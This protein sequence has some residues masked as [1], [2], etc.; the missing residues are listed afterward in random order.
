MP[1]GFLGGGAPSLRSLQLESTGAL[2]KTIPFSANLTRVYLFEDEEFPTGA[3][4]PTLE[5]FAAFLKNSVAIEELTLMEYLP[6]TG[7]ESYYR[8]G[9]FKRAQLTLPF[10]RK[11]VIHDEKREIY[12]FALSVHLPKATSIHFMFH[13]GAY[14]SETDDILDD[15]RTAWTDEERGRNFTEGGAKHL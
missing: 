5:E 1:V 7:F 3:P 15:L 12:R 4:K 10:L 6:R 11:L 2:W 14:P 8:D 13:H 9:Y